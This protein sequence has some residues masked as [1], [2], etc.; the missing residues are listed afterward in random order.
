MHINL[1]NK[2]VLITGGAGDGLGSGLCEAVAE[3]GGRLIRHDLDLE[4]AEKAADKSGDALA[5]AGD[6]SKTEDVDRM[7]KHIIDECGTI[8]GLVNN[9]GIGLG[10]YAIE[11]EE[12]EVDRLY[13]V[14]VKGIWIV[15]RLFVKQLLASREVGHIVNISSVQAFT[16]MHRMALYA[17]AKSAV[18]GLTRGLAIELGQYNIRCNAVA[19]GYIY[20][21]Q[22]LSIIG[23]WTPDP[24]TWIEEHKTDHQCLD[25][26]TS[27]RDC[28]NVVAFLLSDLSR[29]ITG[30]TIYV[31]NGTTNLLYNNKYTK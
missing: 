22:S 8:H 24:E 29:S 10:K 2:N 25:F 15:T 13:D 23:K 18:N 19:P 21:K 14:D 3:A 1:K 4:M 26:F 27:A 7:F 11:A 31:D 5:I 9:A 16:T 20:S 6:I 30:Q 17:G 12:Q 28:G